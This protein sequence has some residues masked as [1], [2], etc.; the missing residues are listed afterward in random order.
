MVLPDADDTVAV[1]VVVI[2][3]VCGGCTITGLPSSEGCPFSVV[4]MPVDSLRFNN[5]EL[6]EVSP[7]RI[8]GG[9]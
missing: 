1:R 7:G 4:A 2:S 8:G 5:N 6:G 9:T 3:V